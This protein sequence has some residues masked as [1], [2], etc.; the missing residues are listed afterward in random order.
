MQE[1][2]HKIHIKKNGTQYDVNLYDNKF[3]SPDTFFPVKVGGTTYYIPATSYLNGDAAGGSTPLRIKKSGT[4]YQIIKKAECNINIPAYDNQK[5]VVEV[6]NSITGNKA[7]YEKTIVVPFGSYFT[8]KVQSTNSQYNAG[9]MTSAS[10]GTITE[11]NINLTASPAT[12]AIP[13]GS[14]RI[15]NDITF[16]V[17]AGITV[18]QVGTIRPTYVRVLPNSTHHLVWDVDVGEN[19]TYDLICSTH[20]SNEWIRHITLDSRDV[21][22]YWSP[23]INNHST[24]VNCY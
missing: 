1:V 3:P 10:S 21:T 11:K 24:D 2:A 19:T 12:I 13:T 9:S 6:T 18:I 5:I 14:L 4:T 17:P 22:L 16:T 7:T 8:A 20:A 23:E 15:R